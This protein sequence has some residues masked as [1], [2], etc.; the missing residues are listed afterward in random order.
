MHA[1][2]RCDLPGRSPTRSRVEAAAK[3]RSSDSNPVAFRRVEA[4]MLIRMRDSHPRSIAKAVS[5]RITGSLDTFVLSLIFTGS[6]KLAVS[7][8]GAEMATKMILYYLHE[9]AWSAI[10]WDQR[11]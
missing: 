5:W 3:F 6:A 7:I 9:R 4:P 8:A 11:G 2:S 1:R 10:P